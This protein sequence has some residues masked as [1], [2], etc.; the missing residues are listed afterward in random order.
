MA[1]ASQQQQRSN[2]EPSPNRVRFETAFEEFED[3]ITTALVDPE[4]GYEE[5]IKREREELKA[6]V[7]LSTK[8][9]SIPNEICL[10]LHPERLTLIRG[11][12]A[13]TP[14]SVTSAEVSWSSAAV[15]SAEAQ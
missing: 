3:G 10:T 14:G 11:G 12:E 13:A 8:P 1:L 4:T 2:R 9:N 15:T 7:T 5:A 6:E